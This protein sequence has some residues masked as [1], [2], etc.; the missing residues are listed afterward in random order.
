MKKQL[1]F[2]AIASLFTSMA[3]AADLYVRDLGAGGSYSTISAAITA[4]ADGDRIIIRPKAGSLPFI[5]NLTID[6]SLSFVSE[7]NFSKYI[8]QG[9]ITVTPAAGRVVSIHNLQISGTNTISVSADTTGG[10]TTLNLLNS[11]T[12]AVNAGVANTT[13]NMS[14]CTGTVITMTHGRVTGNKVTFITINTPTIDTDPSTDDIEIIAN[15]ISGTGSA[16]F[17]SQKNYNFR[18]LNNFIG[19]GFMIIS[20]VKNDSTNEIINNVISSTNT[21]NAANNSIQV[22]SPAGF[23]G[24]VSI[25]NNV[26]YY[27]GPTFGSYY[28]VTASGVSCY[29]YY[30]LSNYSVTMPTITNSG[31]NI[32]ATVSLNS[33]N[34]TVNGLTPNT[35]SPE[36][37]FADIDLSRNDR[38][39][40][41]G[42]NSWTNY[43][44]TT[45]GNKPQVNYLN[46]PRRIYTGTTEMNATG[47]GY[48]K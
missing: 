3:S 24:L 5:E 22:S 12:S 7:I 41:G 36:D 31:N 33:T 8:L 47:S 44:P 29:V 48:S 35:G 19:T 28:P 11:I 16:I 39:N 37:D 1:F 27:I 13:L 46:T 10:R 26:F 42:S 45:V 34:Y 14:G 25:L 9:T 38:G 15:A 17:L 4:A 23:T 20:T 32:V 2:I 43:W 30:N 6:K 21:S 40:F 18:I